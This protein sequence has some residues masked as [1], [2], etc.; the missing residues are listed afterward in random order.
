MGTDDFDDADDEEAPDDH[1]S[2]DFSLRGGLLGLAD[3]LRALDEVSEDRESG[4]VRGSRATI[5]YD[6]SVGTG[7]GSG[8]RRRRSSRGSRRNSG[9]DDDEYLVTARET[10]GEFV[11]VADLPGIDP[12]DVT[13]GF[14][15]DGETLVVGVGED[16][17]QRVSLPW[18]GQATD[19]SYSNGVLEV[20]LREDE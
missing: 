2:Q 5:D 9:G 11:V 16:V 12:E 15:G 4:R 20:H 3:L 10:D 7:L 8:E 14:E 1:R 13:V 19:T 18:P 17:I 6:V